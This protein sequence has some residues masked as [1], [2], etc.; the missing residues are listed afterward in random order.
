MIMVS[1]QLL[2][3]S[4]FFL[5]AYC[6]VYASPGMKV[7]FTGSHVNESPKHTGAP[8]REQTFVA[9]KPDAVQRSL[10]G[11]IIQRFESKGLKLVAVK[12]AKPSREVIEK[13]YEHLKRTSF[14]EDL[15]SFFSSSPVVAM[16]YEGDDAIDVSRKLVGATHPSEAQP[17]TI[18]GDF[19]IGKGRNLVHASDSADNAAREIS[20]WFK[21]EEIF[22]YRKT[23]DDW[24]Y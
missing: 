14:Y 19:C 13:H 20:L 24:L 12:M 8:M 15:I 1:N 21:D 5:G 22:E 2:L 7:P 6:I 3:F 11:A 17:G 23:I 10:L 9:L 18:R 16:V 4:L